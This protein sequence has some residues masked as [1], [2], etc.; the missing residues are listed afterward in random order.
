MAAEPAV[1]VTGAA[2][3]A[4]VAMVP[5]G[6]MGVQTDALGLGL[7]AAMLVTLWLGSIDTRR[8]A[9]AAVGLSGLLAG[10]FSPHAASYVATKFTS[11]SADPS[12]LRM[13][14]ALL[15]AIAA[16][17]LVPIALI[18]AQAIART[19]LSRKGGAE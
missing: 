13:P 7:F 5:A 6:A 4:A 18:G 10:Y 16:P 14:M 19:W 11:L 15:I 3:G 12:A 2:A 17:F 1:T 9:F 8:K